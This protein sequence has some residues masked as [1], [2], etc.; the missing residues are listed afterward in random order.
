VGSVAGAV[1]V[2]AWPLVASNRVSATVM[3]A[4]RAEGI[5]GK[6]AGRPSACAVRREH[7]RAAGAAYSEA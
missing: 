4:R 2:A 7:A 5:A 6:L 3:V 1:H